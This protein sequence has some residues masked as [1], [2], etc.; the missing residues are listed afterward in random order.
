MI[1][2]HAGGIEGDFGV[3]LDDF[4]VIWVHGGDLG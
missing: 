2:G 1:W 3:I 4:K